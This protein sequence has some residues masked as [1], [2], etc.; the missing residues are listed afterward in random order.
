MTGNP[1]FYT[2]AATMWKDLDTAGYRQLATTQKNAKSH[3][4]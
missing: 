2:F 1:F 4:F 3:F